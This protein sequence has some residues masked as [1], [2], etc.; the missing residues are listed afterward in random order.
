MLVMASGENGLNKRSAFLTH[1][2]SWACVT[3]IAASLS[4]VNVSR[5]LLLSTFG[6]KDDS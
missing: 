6:A 2:L 3:V 4:I 5:L 1:I